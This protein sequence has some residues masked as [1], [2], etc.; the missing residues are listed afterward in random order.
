MKEECEE[1]EG[2]G[3]PR[4]SRYCVAEAG[5]S[6][7]AQAGGLQLAMVTLRR[8]PAADAFLLNCGSLCCWRSPLFMIGGLELSWASPSVRFLDCTRM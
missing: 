8:V 7:G 5:A 6:L 3:T 1:W 2:A 4:R